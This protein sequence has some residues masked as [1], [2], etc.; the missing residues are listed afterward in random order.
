MQ[1]T[2]A[3][4]SQCTHHA[5]GPA[6][7]TT[8]VNTDGPARSRTALRP[9]AVRHASSS[10]SVTARTPPTNRAF[11]VLPSSARRPAPCVHASSS[12]PCVP[13]LHTAPT[14]AAVS[15]SST[16]RQRGFSF[17]TA[18]SIASCR[19]ASAGTGRRRTRPR[20]CSGPSPNSCF[21]SMTTVRTYADK[22]DAMS[23]SAVVLPMPGGPT[24]RMEWGCP[25]WLAPAACMSRS[26]RATDA[27]QM[28]RPTR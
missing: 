23:R 19:H 7:S 4:A 12:A 16:T 25:R 27:A 26:A 21:L 22:K 3:A 15:T 20:L 6:T 9:C 11:S 8:D 18:R 13:A 1:S 28:W 17:C 14:S 5:A 2:V 10:L 24:R